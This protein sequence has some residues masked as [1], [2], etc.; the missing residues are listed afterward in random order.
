[1]APVNQL[2][3]S[4]N[5]L[6]LPLFRCLA[7]EPPPPPLLA[8]PHPSHH[9]MLMTLP[10]ICYVFCSTDPPPPPLHSTP[11]P[12]PTLSSLQHCPYR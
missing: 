11:H 12:L 9:P 8:T 6:T 10:S 7:P 1:M 5:I 4:N 2:I 3:K